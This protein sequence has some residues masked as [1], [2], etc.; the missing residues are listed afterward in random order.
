[1]INNDV[2]SSTRKNLIKINIAVVGSFLIIFS[3]CIY[4]YFKLQTYKNV[5][6]HLKEELE[7]IGMQ[8]DVNSLHV[9]PKLLDPKNMVYIYANNKVKYF[10]PNGY[11]KDS[12]PYNNSSELGFNTYKYNSYTFRELKFNVDGY[13]IQIIRNIDSEMIL[14]NRLLI[15]FFIGTVLAIVT[16]Y[17]IALYLTKKALIPIEKTWNNQVKFIQ[18]ASH[19]LRTPI[20]IISSKL[21]S[22]LKYPKNSI[23]DEIETIAD[24]MKENRRLKK[25]VND[26]LDLTKEESITKLNIEELDVN[27]LVKGISNDYIEISY[28]HDKKFNYNFKGNNSFIVTDKS[29][30]R[31][32]IVIFIDNA[33]KYTDKGDYIDINVFNRESDCIISIKDSGIGIE[34]KDINLV[35]DRFFRSDIVREKGIDGSGIGLSIAS[36]IIKSLKG[37]IKV[38]SKLTEGT[39]FKIILPKKIKNN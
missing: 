11:F 34:E 30:L 18:D 35:F 2:L 17:F 39:E 36:M 27:E 32:L 22:L 23:S 29:K 26:L 38:Y 31:Q 8:L 37:D 12:I 14:L 15:V 5:D 19:E 3:L 6:A 10:T 4:S 16:T 33:F 20:T 9:T 13:T 21:E 25:M 1:M 24:A 7:Y 28:V